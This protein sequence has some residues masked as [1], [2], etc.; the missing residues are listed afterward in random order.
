MINNMINNRLK[1]V[2]RLWL[3]FLPL[4][5]IAGV[6]SNG[7]KGIAVGG[8]PDGTSAK[9]QISKDYEIACWQNGQQ[10]IGETGSGNT[11]I[12]SDL[13]NSSIVLRANG[14]KHTATIIG[15]GKSLCM[16]RSR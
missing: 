9:R 14:G 12:S 13:L 10:V 6:E 1:V 16:V 11:S 5:A 2:F 3:C 8:E 7:G 4:T 15:I